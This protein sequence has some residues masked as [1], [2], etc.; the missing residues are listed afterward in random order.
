MTRG[1]GFR[2]NKIFKISP[3]LTTGY[4]SPGEYDESLRHSKLTLA[5][6]VNIGILD[7]AFSPRWRLLIML[8][9]ERNAEN[10]LQLFEDTMFANRSQSRVIK[11]WS[12]LEWGQFR[13]AEFGFDEVLSS[14][15]IICVTHIYY[16]VLHDQGKV[17]EASFNLRKITEV[18]AVAWNAN[19]RA[20]LG[21]LAS[22]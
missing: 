6:I 10:K 1:R 8:H 2:L 11:T 22:R 15:L 17:F 5:G 4:N 18:F 13:E 20:L 16:P 3:M 19:A 12:K 21:L 14:K 7:K 9:Y